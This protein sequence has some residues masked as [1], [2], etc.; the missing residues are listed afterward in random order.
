LA[1]HPRYRI[2]RLPG[3]GGTGV[4]YQTKHRLMERIVALRVISLE[5]TSDPGVVERFRREVKTAA[6]QSHPNIVSAYDAEQAGDVQFLVMEYVEGRDLARLVEER[7][8]LPVPLACE[9]ARQVALGLQHAFEKGL[10]HRD[11]T[12]SNLL[13]AGRASAASSCSDGISLPEPARTPFE[14][15]P[16]LKDLGTV[17]ILDFGLARLA[18][19]RGM[20]DPSSP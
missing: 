17:K 15:R 13:L 19:E 9:F 12:P 14:Q 2:V 5:P 1:K 18:R 4:M 10:V 6:R 20:G 11:I 8:Q 7:G 3:A 16:Q